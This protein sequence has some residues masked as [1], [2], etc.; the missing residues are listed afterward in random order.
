M[1][2]V[3]QGGGPRRYSTRTE[4]MMPEWSSSFRGGGDGRTGHGL[5]HGAVHRAVRLAWLAPVVR[6]ANRV[7]RS[8]RT[9]SIRGGRRLVG[10]GPWDG[11]LQGAGVVE[12]RRPGIGTAVDGQRF[13][14][15]G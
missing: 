13:R 7:A 5:E 3:A 12:G 15:T 8:R 9:T 1:E 6:V 14:L 10:P 11:S 2:L 4:E